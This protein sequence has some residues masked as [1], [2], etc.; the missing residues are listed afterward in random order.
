[1]TR[2]GGA[3]TAAGRRARTAGRAQRGRGPHAATRPAAVGRAAPLRAAPTNGPATVPVRDRRL[4][5][6]RANGERARWRS[7]GPAAR[8]S[9]SIASAPCTSCRRIRSR[10]RRGTAPA[11]LRHL[12]GRARARI[13]GVAGEWIEVRFG[14]GFR[15]PAIQ[16]VVWHGAGVRKPPMHEPAGHGRCYGDLKDPLSRRG[17]RDGR[18]GWRGDRDVPPDGVVG[19]RDRSAGV[20]STCRDGAGRSDLMVIRAVGGPVIAAGTRFPGV[21]ST[22]A[23]LPGRSLSC[24]VTT[25]RPRYGQATMAAR[26]PGR[27]GRRSR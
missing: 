2:R 27:H 12:L 3:P 21:R 7:R 16:A 10:D 26:A 5:H 24:R 6:L 14:E 11:L 25:Q 18:C 9:S 13:A 1:M 22:A 23:W 19:R 8:R 4:T 15:T 20:P 17:W